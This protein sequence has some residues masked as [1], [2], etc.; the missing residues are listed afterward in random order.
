M[1]WFEGGEKI[2]IAVRVEPDVER[3]VQWGAASPAHH[4]RHSPSR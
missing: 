3:A 4:R 2:E 1:Q